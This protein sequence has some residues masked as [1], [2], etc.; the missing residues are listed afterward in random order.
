[1]K[2]PRRALYNLALLY[3]NYQVEIDG[4]LARLGWLHSIEHIVKLEQRNFH[5]IVEVLHFV[6]QY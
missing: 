3:G 4:I 2:D 6:A 1:M 5:V